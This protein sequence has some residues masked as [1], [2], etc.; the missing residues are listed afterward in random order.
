MTVQELGVS[1]LTK[2]DIVLFFYKIEKIPDGVI[3]ILELELARSK[4]YRARGQA[5]PR[6]I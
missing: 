3:F 6:I 4:M 5:V 1:A 2:I